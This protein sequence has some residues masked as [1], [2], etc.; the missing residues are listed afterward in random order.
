MLNFLI[1][2]LS[3]LSNANIRFIEKQ[4]NQKKYELFTKNL[5]FIE[6]DNLRREIKFMELN[7]MRI[8]IQEPL[9]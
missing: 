7:R 5:T 8:I 6:F 3:Y 9:N 2:L 1:I 4:L